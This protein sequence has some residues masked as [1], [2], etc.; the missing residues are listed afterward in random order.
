M[1]LYNFRQDNWAWNSPTFQLPKLCL[2]N[3]R[4]SVDD[5][6]AYPSPRLHLTTQWHNNCLSPPHTS[7]SQ[8]QGVS[9]PAIRPIT[10]SSQS[11]SASYPSSFHLVHPPSRVPLHLKPAQALRQRLFPFIL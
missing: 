10:V 1:Q 7:T 3:M 11:Q 4:E 5:P 9:Y 6:E 2:T 8:S